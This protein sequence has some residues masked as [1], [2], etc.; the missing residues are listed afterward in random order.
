MIWHIWHTWEWEWSSSDIIFDSYLKVW[1]DAL[2]AVRHLNFLKSTSCSVQSDKFGTSYLHV[3]QIQ[4][5]SW[6]VAYRLFTILSD[7]VAITR[8]FIVIKL[9][10]NAQLLLQE[11]RDIYTSAP[12]LKWVRVSSTCTTFRKAFKGQTWLETD[13]VG[14]R[15]R[16]FVAAQSAPLCSFA[17]FALIQSTDC[18]VYITSIGYWF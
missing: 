9:D 10:I 16:F 18:Q 11:T 13:S 14:S 7:I 15:L 17:H 12:R 1:F 3:G 5:H 4:D 2:Q 6:Q 8:F